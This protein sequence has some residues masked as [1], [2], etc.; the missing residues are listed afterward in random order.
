MRI[1]G[2]ID[3]KIVVLLFLRG[4]FEEWKD[5]YYEKKRT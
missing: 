4:H 2:K 1:N 3:D 5:G